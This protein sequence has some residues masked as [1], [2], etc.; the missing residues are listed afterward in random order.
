[1][2][3]LCTTDIGGPLITTTGL[4]GIATATDCGGQV[5]LKKNSI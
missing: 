4:I 2:N 3:T 1:M 5:N